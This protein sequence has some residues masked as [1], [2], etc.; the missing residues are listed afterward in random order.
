[1]QLQH[2][3]LFVSSAAT[4]ALLAGGTH[5]QTLIRSVSGPAANALY[6]KACIVI[7]D[8]N[9]DGYE[10]L[11]VG[12]PGLNLG[13]GAIYCLSGAYLGFGTGAQTLWSL[14][15][16]GPTDN[17]GDLFGWALADVGDVTFDG[18]HDFLVGEPG[19]DFNGS[20]DLG[21]VV[22]VNGASHTASTRIRGY[23]ASCLFGY[24][25]AA[26]GDA[27]GDGRS[28][29][30]IGAPGLVSGASRIYSLNGANVWT[31]GSID[32]LSSDAEDL[33]GTAEFGAALA[34]GF[35]L[36]GD[37]LPEIVVGSP[38]TL[39]NGAAYLYEISAFAALNHQQSYLSQIPGERMGASVDGGQDFNGDGVPDIVVGAPKSPSGTTYELGRAVVLSGAKLIAHT[40]PFELY[41]LS[42]V[43]GFSGSSHF[44]YGAA[45][46]ATGD[47]NGDGIGEILVG[48]PDYFSNQFTFPG[49]GFA[50][51]YSGATG[52]RLTTVFGT[53][54]ERIGDALG[55]A[56]AD[57]DGDGFDEFAIAGWSSD[58]GGTDTGVVKLYR[59]F[60]VGPTTYCTAKLNSLGCTPSIWFSGAPDESS[61]APFLITAS[62]FINQK[63]GLLFYS[64]APASQAFQGG[65]KCAASPTVRSGA[66]NSGGS[67]SGSDCTGTYSFDFNARIQSG[68]D[69]SLVAGA[70]C[71]AQ[72]WSRDPQSASTT[73]LSNALRFVISP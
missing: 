17:T 18:V 34:G 63:T 8:Q 35:D 57:F 54:N 24:A 14:A 58:T 27:T 9:A 3:S 28:E 61:T 36:D 15:L 73:S 13:R 49:K 66:L 68:V 67:A 56:L 32:A 21:A 39:G 11:L 10:D 62:N 45:V 55:G 65:F 50:A 30:V 60:P 5:A 20:S 38:A 4:A 6:G 16:N 26:C 31:N 1:M 23:A 12:A 29:V 33:F 59:L 70:E 22:L 71:Y 47:L 51:I 64:H 44:H 48:A 46:R 41:N 2:L 52:S 42:T 37:G 53:N 7:G 72:Y 43:A 25:I 69:P 40:A 19:Y